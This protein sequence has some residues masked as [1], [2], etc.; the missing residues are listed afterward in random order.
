MTTYRR[1]LIL[2]FLARSFI[3]TWFRFSNRDSPSFSGCIAF[4]SSIFVHETPCSSI[5]RINRASS[6]SVQPLVLRL[7][8]G[9]GIARRSSLCGDRACARTGEPAASCDPERRRPWASPPASSRPLSTLAR[10]LCRAC[11]GFSARRRSVATSRSSVS[12]SSSLS[13][14]D[15]VSRLRLGGRPRGLRSALLGP[16]V[17]LTG[18]TRTAFS[19][20]SMNAG[21]ELLEASG[22]ARDREFAMFQTS[23]LEGSE[24]LFSSLGGASVEAGS[25]RGLGTDRFIG[26]LWDLS[27]WFSV[28]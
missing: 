28:C 25:R 5:K 13:E 16:D 20:R 1:N 12:Y 6:A 19:W 15:S 21:R 17:W 11:T 2:K 3:C 10:L 9:G 4:S 18:E 14:A 26:G 27:G 8:P 23:L 7:G 22:V 24:R